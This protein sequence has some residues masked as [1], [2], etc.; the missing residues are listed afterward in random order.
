MTRGDRPTKYYDKVREEG[1]GTIIF[2]Y[3]REYEAWLTL[4]TLVNGSSTQASL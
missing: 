4:L 3:V 2:I 1:C